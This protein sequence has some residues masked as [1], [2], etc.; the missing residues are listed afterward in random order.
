MARA[1]VKPIKHLAKSTTSFLK[2]SSWGER[3]V[4][5]NSLQNREGDNTVIVTPRSET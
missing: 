1:T 4:E 2:Q 3:I 5:E